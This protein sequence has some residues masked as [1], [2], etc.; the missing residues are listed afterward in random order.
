MKKKTYIKH[1]SVRKEVKICHSRNR[2]YTCTNKDGTGT[3]NIKGG[4]G[5]LLTQNMETRK[6][7]N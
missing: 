6:S 2:S 1:I 7:V 4:G 3:E 5:E